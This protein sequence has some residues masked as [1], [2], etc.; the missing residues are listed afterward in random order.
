MLREVHFCFLTPK[1]GNA[2]EECEDSISFGIQRRNRLARI[3][4][5]VAIADGATESSFSKEWSDLLTK[6]F[7]RSAIS[8]PDGL[9]QNLPGLRTEWEAMIAEKTLPW[10]AEEK[11]EKGAYSAF[12]GL[13]ISFMN[14]SYEAIA[15][16]DC[17]LFHIRNEMV[18]STFPIMHSSEFGN[19]P[20][21]VSSKPGMNIDL[22]SKINITEMDLMKGDT[23]FL[24]SDALSH[25]FMTSNEMSLQPWE[26]LKGFIKGKRLDKGDMEAWLDDQRIE[27]NIKNDDVVLSIIEF[28]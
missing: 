15:V 1:K 2:P 6:S 11:A 23:L 17:C 25:W 14:Y 3:G 13:H 28:S 5:N 10:Y 9:L 12:L 16:G 8:L 7:C 24:M 4:L 27:K 22:G 20:Y 26:I 19:K 21:L 18:I